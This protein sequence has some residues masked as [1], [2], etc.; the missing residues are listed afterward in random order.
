[1]AEKKSFVNPDD[2]NKL[3]DKVYQR[4][5]IDRE[6]VLE[7]LT[8]IDTTDAKVIIKEVQTWLKNLHEDPKYDKVVFPRGDDDIDAIIGDLDSY[9]RVQ[10]ETILEYKMKS[11]KTLPIT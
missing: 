10:P 2:V 6:H 7:F 4:G 9:G 8:L 11:N 3:N 5:L 1:M